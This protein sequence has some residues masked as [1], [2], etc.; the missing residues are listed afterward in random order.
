MNV[1]SNVDIGTMDIWQGRALR[2]MMGLSV[3]FHAGMLLFISSIS[4]LFPAR[5]IPPVVIVE[6]T[7]PPVSTL[8][9]EEPPP[10][11]SPAVRQTVASPS[12]PHIPSP[13]ATK[14]PSRSEKWL[15]KLDAGLAEIPEAPISRKMGKRGGI[16]VRQWETEAAPR[17][18]DFAPAVA[19]EDKVLLARI[20]ELEG[21]VKTGGVSGVGEGEEVEVSSMFG[22]AGAP[23]GDPIPPWI[24]DMIRRIVRGHLPELEA[25]Y[26]AAIRRDPT[27]RGR[28]LIRFRIDPSG[29][30]IQAAP[31]GSSFRNEGFIETVVTKVRGWT[32]DPTDGRTVEVLY[33]F[34][35]IAPS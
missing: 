14:R 34:V 2:W 17:P 16:P 11:P 5:P 23:G 28:L 1:V 31:G 10:P 9:E 30:V 7:E 20:A 32:F 18:G 3:L 29:K 21:K 27:I 24:R 15:K 25:L 19:P 4:S 33:P 13:P 8:P 22:G 26:S 6:L 12:R 35:F